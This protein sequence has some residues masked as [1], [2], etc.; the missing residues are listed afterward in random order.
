VVTDPIVVHRLT[1]AGVHYY[2]QGDRTYEVAAAV[3]LP[4]D[5]CGSDPAS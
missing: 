1:T 4:G 5:S 3:L 2:R